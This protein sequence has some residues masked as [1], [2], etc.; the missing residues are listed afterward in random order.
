ML[1]VVSLR[2]S[3]VLIISTEAGASVIF[4]LPNSEEEITCKFIVDDDDGYSLTYDDGKQTLL[5][6]N[7]LKQKC[8]V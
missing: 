1:D 2:I 5:S 8:S 4:S 3:L 7:V 6:K